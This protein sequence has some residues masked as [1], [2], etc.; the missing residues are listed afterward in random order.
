MNTREQERCSFWSAGTG[1]EW[2]PLRAKAASAYGPDSGIGTAK[3]AEQGPI[4]GVPEGVYLF[5]DALG[6]RTGVLREMETGGGG[7]GR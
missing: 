1:G 4:G 5:W 2:T 6:E 7:R 3:G